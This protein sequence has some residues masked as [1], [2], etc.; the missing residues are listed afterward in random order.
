[1][2]A[3]LLGKTAQAAE[4]GVQLRIDDRTD[5]SA[6][7]VEQ[8]DAVTIL[9][10][11]VDNAL[12]AVSERA[13]RVVVVELH[14]SAAGL[15]VRVSDSGA[16]RPR[17]PRRAGVRAR[18]VDQDLRRP[19]APHGFVLALRPYLNDQTKYAIGLT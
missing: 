4:R 6:L 12:D 16:G 8:R 7:P 11:L 18:L 15:T 9:G 10:N 3:L 2:S 13:E 1:M 14:G 17:G 5:L 19:G